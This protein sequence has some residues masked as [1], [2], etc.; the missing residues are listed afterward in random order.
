LREDNF[1]YILT[2]LIIIFSLKQYKVS[3]NAKN[4]HFFSKN[5]LASHSLY[6]EKEALTGPLKKDIFLSMWV[7]MRRGKKKEL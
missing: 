7:W 1:S 4:N 5:F 2:P 6:S 3:E